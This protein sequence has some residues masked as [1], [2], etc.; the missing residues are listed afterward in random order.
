MVRYD[1]GVSRL[2]IATATAFLCTC[3]STPSPRPFKDDVLVELGEPPARL[4]PGTPIADPEAIAVA[5]VVA[6]RWL[7]G[8]AASS[9]ETGRIRGF[10]FRIEEADP[11][12]GFLDALSKHPAGAVEA[13]SQCVFAADGFQTS[14]G[15]DAARLLMRDI[16]VDGNRA[17]LDSMSGMIMGRREFCGCQVL[18]LLENG[19][20]GWRITDEVGGVCY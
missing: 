20:G 11:P 19:E 15:E 7:D 4:S 8:Y 2:L 17:S 9:A 16:K 1:A 13:G 6:A 18:W 3:A 12:R 14:A 5:T 10:C